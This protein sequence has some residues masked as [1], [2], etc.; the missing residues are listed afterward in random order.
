MESSIGTHGEYT[1]G[2]PEIEEKQLECGRMA[3]RSES[4]QAPP[5]HQK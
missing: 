3:A 2:E 4:L 5:G 1:N